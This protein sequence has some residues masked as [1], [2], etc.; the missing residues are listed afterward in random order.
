MR[1]ETSHRDWVI[2]Q[3]R[4]SGG[5]AYGPDVYDKAERQ[6]RERDSIYSA[7]SKLIKQGAVIKGAWEN[8]PPQH[9]SWLHLPSDFA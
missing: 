8:R 6:G 5:R 7:V 4:Q 3:L 1:Y 9:G 2:D